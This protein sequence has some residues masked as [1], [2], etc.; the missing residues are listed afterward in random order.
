MDAMIIGLLIAVVVAALVAVM[1]MK[2]KK[3]AQAAQPGSLFQSGQGQQS[4]DQTPQGQW[5]QPPPGG[6]GGWG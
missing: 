2:R 3:K 5:Q 6:Q 4:W 1:L